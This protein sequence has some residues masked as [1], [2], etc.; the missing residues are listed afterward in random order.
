MFCSKCGVENNDQANFCKSC[1]TAMRQK[2]T[3]QPI[4]SVASQSESQHSSEVQY[5]SFWRRGA[6]AI[7][8]WQM[9]GAMSVG[10]SRFLSTK[11]NNTQLIG[12]IVFLLLVGTYFA[13]L[14]SRDSAT[15]GKRLFFLNVLR[16]DE[17]KLSFAGAAWRFCG[18]LISS[19]I[20]GIGYFIQ[21]FTAKRQALHDMMANS[22]VIQT[23]NG[24]NG[25]VIAAW[26]FQ[27]LLLMVTVIVAWNSREQ[28]KDAALGSV[29]SE[30]QGSHLVEENAIPPAYFLQKTTVRI[31]PMEGDKSLSVE[32]GIVT[33]ACGNSVIRI[34]GM[35]KALAGFFQFEGMIVIRG[36]GKELILGDDKDKVGALSDYN[37]MACVS[38]PTGENLLIWSNC[39]GS[40]CG[41]DF[42]F[43]L[44]DLN[45]QTYL[46]K[47]VDAETASRVL[48]SRLPYEI[49]RQ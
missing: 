16:T 21:P 47:Y 26:V 40:V 24:R 7:F 30:V 13:L 29:Q 9:V 22:I 6:A 11:S 1:G 44:I 34:V 3:E 15:I 33:G 27:I 32:K 35:T 39:G 20:F 28:A 41:D 2:I 49:N 48:G 37:G 17:Q 45:T 12:S 23:K 5:A 31:H 8:D 10:V 36:E 4:Q 14:E 46:L 19:V 42:H 25:L 43:Y 18:R 38:S